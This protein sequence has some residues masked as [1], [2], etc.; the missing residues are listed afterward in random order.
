MKAGGPSAAIR[1]GDSDSTIPV[2]ARRSCACWIGPPR[3][4]LEESYEIAADL[5]NVRAARDG[6]RDF[7]LQTE[8]LEDPPDA[9]LAVDSEAPEERP[10][11]EDGPGA[12][13]ERL[14][15]VGATTDPA[16][17][18]HLDAAVRCLRHLGQC[19]DRRQRPVEL[20]A[21]VV[22]DDDAIDTG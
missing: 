10:P 21:A 9:V 4:R 20:A 19:L 14:Q 16:V 8:D 13:R 7:E 1:A 6:H 17:E 12:E 3:E 22:R 5:G 15:H 11:D 18:E 2:A